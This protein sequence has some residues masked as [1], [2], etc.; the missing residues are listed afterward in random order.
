MKLSLIKKFLRSVHKLPAYLLAIM[1]LSII[2]CDKNDPID[3]IKE[4][5]ELLTESSWLVSELE[6]SGIDIYAAV[7]GATV[8]FESDGSYSTTIDPVFNDVWSTNGSW[9][10][11]SVDLIM[12]N[13][14]NMTIS[15]VGQS[16]I[17]LTYIVP[18]PGGRISGLDGKYV[19]KL[20]R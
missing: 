8:T 10:L 20:S 5:T 1:L 3:P 16:S 7:A 18:D 14:I 11:L 15:N 12:I 9:L 17:T 2:S 19:M 4:R 6:Q 13:D